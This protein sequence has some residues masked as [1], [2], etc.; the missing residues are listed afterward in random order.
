MDIKQIR[1]FF[2][3]CSLINFTLLFLIGI[4]FIVGNNF[5]YE[6]I[7]SVVSISKDAYQIYMLETLGVWKTCVWVFFI[8]PYISLS[9]MEKKKVVK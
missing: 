5:L 1:T 4:F 9:I 3:W 2:G 7:S 8:I 6:I